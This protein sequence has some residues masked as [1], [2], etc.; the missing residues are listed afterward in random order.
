MKSFEALS[1]ISEGQ[2][3]EFEAEGIIAQEKERLGR[4]RGISKKVRAF[5]GALLLITAFE[6]G[7]AASA[8]AK[9]ER[10]RESKSIEWVDREENLT[11]QNP[12]QFLRQ[13]SK[14]PDNIELIVSNQDRDNSITV[15]I[16]LVKDRDAAKKQ[17]DRYAMV[18]KTNGDIILY[19]ALSAEEA[20]KY[21]V[22]YA[23]LT[24]H[25]NRQ[26]EKFKAGEKKL[27]EQGWLA[28]PDGRHGHYVSGSERIVDGKEVHTEVRRIYDNSGFDALTIWEIDEDGKEVGYTAVLK[29]SYMYDKFIS[30]AKSNND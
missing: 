14:L 20:L 3:T 10:T 12:C 13:V 5:A 27:M 17:S 1:N 18:D 22:E 25:F 7:V 8:E 15:D 26:L 23:S 6:A 16:Y 28:L 29:N 19:R 24:P 21:G 11:K 9:T 30:F 4:F 2:D